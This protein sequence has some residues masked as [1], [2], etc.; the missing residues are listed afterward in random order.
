MTGQLELWQPGWD[1]EPCD[2]A[3]P[4]VTR[5][6]RG[7]PYANLPDQPRPYR[8]TVTVAAIDDYEPQEQ[9]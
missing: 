9:T 3:E 2:T 4:P 8:T 5:S 1:L 7:N 6:Q